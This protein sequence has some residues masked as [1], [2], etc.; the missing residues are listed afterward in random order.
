MSQGRRLDPRAIVDPGA[1][2]GE[3]VEVGPWSMIG[4][5]VE[6]GDRCV[7]GP[8]VI[9]RGPTRMGPDNRVFQFA[10]LGEEPPGG[11]AD[12]D[13]RRGR[14]EIG[15]ANIFREGVTVHTGSMVSGQGL[16]KIGAGNLLLAYAHVAHDC[17]LG[18]RIVMANNVSLAGHVRVADH[19]NFGGYAQVPQRRSVAE[20][21]MVNA[22]SLV[23]KDIPAY[24]IADGRPAVAAGLNLVGLRRLGIANEA[25]NVL[26][27][28]YAIVFRQQLTLSA[29]VAKLQAMDATE[30][31]QLSVFLASIGGSQL[32][33]LPAARRG[34]RST[35]G[36]HV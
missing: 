11:G 21:A 16:T 35:S 34:H 19:A 3:D 8:H 12:E 36:K 5:D 24:V 6:I 17:V 27:D 30:C 9:I 2:L 14:L 33:I 31:P 26:K 4:P 18:D 10:C 7:I 29:A 15:A 28:A 23:V 25:I 13:E 32:G 1:R 22:L 20:G